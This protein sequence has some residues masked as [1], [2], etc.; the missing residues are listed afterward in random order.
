MDGIEIRRLGPQ[1]VS[2]LRRAEG[3]FDHPVNVTEAKALAASEAH[4]LIVALSGDRVVGMACGAVIRQPDKPP[5]FYL[6]EIG[7]HK[8]WQRQGVGRA[9]LRAVLAEARAMGCAGFWLATEAENAAA[10]ALFDQAGG[11]EQAGVV[12]YHWPIRSGEG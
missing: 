10:R 3:V 1:D 4:A 11:T 6:D 7:V 9:L 5:A 12:T 2:L 8:D